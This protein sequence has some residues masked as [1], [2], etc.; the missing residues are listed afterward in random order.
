MWLWLAVVLA[1]T[2]AALGHA[3]RL[4]RRERERWRRAAEIAA[5]ERARHAR[6]S[7]EFAHYREQLEFVRER[8]DAF[9][10]DPSGTPGVDLGDWPRR[11]DAFAT[12]L[13]PTSEAYHV[14]SAAYRGVNAVGHASDPERAQPVLSMVDEALAAVD[15]ALTLVCNS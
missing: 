1:A 4:R 6:L 10:D 2:L 14:L 8:L 5:A 15:E 13:G 7:L 9:L 3:E 12:V 11:A